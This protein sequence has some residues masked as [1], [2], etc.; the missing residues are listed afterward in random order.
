MELRKIIPVMLAALLALSVLASCGGGEEPGIS[1]IDWENH[2][3]RAEQLVTALANGDFSIV[4]QGF[5]AEMQ[6]AL[7][8]RALANNWKAMTNQAGAFVS[9]EGTELEPHDE[10]DIYIVTTRHEK[11]GMNTRIVFSADGQVA[12]LFFT[13]A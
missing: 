1:H 8:V 10:Y 12:G 3:A 6:R 5:D 9:I 7:S 11:S 13:F 2:D 4:A